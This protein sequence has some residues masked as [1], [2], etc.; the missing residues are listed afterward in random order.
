[1][2]IQG[3]LFSSAHWIRSIHLEKM[4]ANLWIF[5]QP[6][7]SMNVDNDTVQTLDPQC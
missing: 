5:R 2:H 4:T 7:Q 3:I 1:M 6:V